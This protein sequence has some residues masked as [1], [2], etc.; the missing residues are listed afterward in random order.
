MSEMVDLIVDEASSNAGKIQENLKKQ[1][2]KVR[3]GR[4]SVSL[5][6]DVRV[7]YYGQT[8]PLRQM[9]NVT[10]PEPRLLVVQPF[11]PSVLKDVEKAILAADLGLNPHNDGKVLRVVIPELTQERRKELTRVVGK[12]AEE[13]RVSVRQVRREANEELKKAEKDK[14][15][16]EDELH[17]GMEIVQKKIDKVIEALDKIAEAKEKELLEI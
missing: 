11:D 6:D 2:G 16:T 10:V 7:N 17:Q 13:H 3:T 12:I 15:I 5:L 14:E 1:L 9:A 8:T 4:A